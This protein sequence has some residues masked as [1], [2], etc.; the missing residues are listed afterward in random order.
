MR[1]HQKIPKIVSAA[2][3]SLGA[4]LF[5]SLACVETSLMEEVID[6]YS[7]SK[8]GWHRGDG[9]NQNNPQPANA[10]SLENGKNLYV[11]YCEVCHGENGAGDG[12]HAK[13]MN[14]RPA[15][16]SALGQ[17]KADYYIYLQISYGREGMPIW[18]K[19]LGETDRWDLVNYVMSLSK[20]H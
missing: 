6:N 8:H 11:S 2:F 7:N 18:K 12:Q 15:N 13:N 20:D 4:A 17:E 5:V 9:A 19:E 10:A 1:K 16:L 14:P 3:M